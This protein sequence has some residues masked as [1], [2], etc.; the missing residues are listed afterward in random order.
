MLRLLQD[1]QFERVGGNQGITTH[2][3]ILAATNQNLEQ[4]IAEG[5]FRSDLYYRLKVVTIRVPALRERK[6]DIPELA[7]HFLY[8]FDRQLNLEIRGFAPDALELLGQYS[9]PGNVRELQGA[10][11]EA[12]LRNAGRM[13]LPES[14]QL[15][16]R[17]GAGRVAVP[18]PDSIGFDL[19]G[20]IEQL[21]AD[22]QKDVF[23]RLLREVEFVLLTRALRHTH[24]HQA[25][26]SDLLGINR[27]TLRN[28]L[29]DL[30]IALEKV[31]ADRSADG[32]AGAVDR[33]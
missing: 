13:L 31:I 20:R 30:G 32:E 25:Q 11:K 6:E 15:S 2:V 28:K 18:A 5:K 3:R 7:H 9:W 27:T 33:E 8:E 1:Q 22:G 26:A 29:R 21:L 14:F 16:S 12:M 4:R 10:I 19:A 23:G 17:P 24:G